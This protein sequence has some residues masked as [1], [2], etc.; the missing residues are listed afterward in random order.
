MKILTEICYLFYFYVTSVKVGPFSNKFQ[1]IGKQ[2]ATVILYSLVKKTKI[3]QK[4]PN[5]HYK[6]HMNNLFGIS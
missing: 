1:M 4:M 5:V 6:I 2:S 3:S